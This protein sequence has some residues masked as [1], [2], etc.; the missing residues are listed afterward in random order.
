MAASM[1]NAG[2]WHHIAFPHL[3][4]T[5]GLQIFFMPLNYAIKTTKNVISPK[6][7]FI[8]LCNDCQAVSKADQQG[9]TLDFLMDF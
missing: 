6:A 2:V 9:Y 1:E 5:E 7:N 3:F 8:E 4:W